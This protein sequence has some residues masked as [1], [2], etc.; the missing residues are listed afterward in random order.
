MAIKRTSHAVYDCTYH[1]VWAS[2]YLKWILHGEIQKRVG[3]LFGEIAANF[4]FEIDTKKISAE[5]V[6]IFLS[7]PPKYSMQL[8]CE[9]PE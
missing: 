9:I 3:E 1:F 4:G 7:F 2:K 8:V 5:H 6:H